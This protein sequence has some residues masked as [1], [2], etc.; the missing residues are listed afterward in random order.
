MKLSQLKTNEV[1]KVLEL[2]VDNKIENVTIYNPMGER[3]LQ[4][5][6]MIAGGE[7]AEGKIEEDTELLGKQI[8]D[9]LF[10]E[11]TD[12]EISEED[13]IAEI[14][15]NPSEVTSRIIMELNEIISELQTEGL[16]GKIMQV[17]A[18]EK[19][20]LGVALNIK[21]N[22]VVAEVERLMEIEDNI[23]TSL[24]DILNMTQSEETEKALDGALKIVKDETAKEKIEEIKKEKSE[25]NKAK[26]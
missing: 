2:F 18:I 23:L 25:S 19:T 6:N 12:L 17:N 4:L 14:I 5:V 11:C 8:Y 10:R 26:K 1:R 21:N 7:N 20:I 9:I 16:V 24:K 3:R 13:D 15:D 22:R